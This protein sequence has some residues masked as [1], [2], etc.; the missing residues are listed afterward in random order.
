M[1]SVTQQCVSILSLE[2]NI[3]A[4]FNFKDGTLFNFQF[5]LMINKGI[6]HCCTSEELSAINRSKV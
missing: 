2:L 5:T 3:S 6:K 4:L 1:S